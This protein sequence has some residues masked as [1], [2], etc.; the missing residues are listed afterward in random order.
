LTRLH[1]PLRALPPHSD[2]PFKLLLEASQL[3]P[4]IL[5]L[6]TLVDVTLAYPTHP[7]QLST[8]WG[9]AIDHDPTLTDTIRTDILPSLIERL[10]LSPQAGTIRIV[11]YSLLTLSRAHEELLALLLSEADF[12]VPALKDAYAVLPQFPRNEDEVRAKEGTLLLCKA[13]QDAMGEVAKEGLLRLMGQS[14]AEELERLGSGTIDEDFVSAVK[15]SRDDAARSDPVS[16]RLLPSSR[17]SAV[18]GNDPQLL[19]DENVPSALHH[20]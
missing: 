16:L 10:R 7:A 4:E 1:E 18:R 8:L 11:T 17:R 13:I 2:V 20:F 9:R 12:I 5:D 19:A 6:P 15:R 14:I 3:G